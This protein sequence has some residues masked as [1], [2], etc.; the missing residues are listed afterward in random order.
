MTIIALQRGIE[1]MYRIR[2]GPS[3][4]AFLVD[5]SGR[6]N[7]IGNCE[8]GEQMIV[9]QS[10]DDVELGLYL[11]DELLAVS[12][13]IEELCDPRVRNFHAGMQLVEG[14]SHFVLSVW[15]GGMN[16]QLSAFELELQAEV[17]KF[18]VAYVVGSYSNKESLIK[19][20]F[21]DFG[22]ASD[23]SPKVKERYVR[24]NYLARC[25]CE[26]LLNK[27]KQA[28]DIPAMLRELRRFY[29]MPLANKLLAI[30][31]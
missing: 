31:S 15:C 5:R 10:G 11:S 27:Y 25:F 22:L 19:R 24:A 13:R 8:T 23:L 3:V 28:G 21:E 17:D 20:L 7:L 29:R 2:P 12:N 16:R 6:D 26:K 14:V 1:A 30:A 18:V 4:D 9:V